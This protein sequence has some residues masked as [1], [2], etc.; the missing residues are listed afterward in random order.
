MRPP[1]AQRAGSWVAAGA[2]LALGAL[3]AERLV[4]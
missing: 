2:L 3:L 4:G 1:R